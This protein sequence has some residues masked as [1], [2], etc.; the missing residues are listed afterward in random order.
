MKKIYSI[1][2]LTLVVFI[3]NT[4]FGQ[5]MYPGGDTCSTAV[6]I[7]VAD[8]YQTP[9]DGPGG[10]HWYSFVAPCDG[11]LAV[12]D[13]GGLNSDKRIHSGVCGSLTL[14]AAGTWADTDVEVTMSSGDSVYIVVNDNWEGQ[15]YFN[16]EFDGCAEIDSALLDIQGIVYYDMNNNGV[17][18]LDESGTFLTPIISD[19]FGVFTVSGVDGLYYSSVASLDDGNYTI[20]PNL[21]E[22]WAVSSDSVSY[23]FEVND[24]YEQLD[25]L[26]FGLYPDSLFNEVTENLI[27]SFPRCN[28]TINYWLNIQNTGTTV[29]SGLIHL[30][31][32]DSLYYVSADVA[33]DSIVGQ[34]L[35]WNYEDL[36]FFDHQAMVVQV[37]TP[38]GLA[39]TVSSN[40]NV[41][42]DSLGVELFSST[43]TLEQIIVCAYD[44]NDKTPTPLGE[45]E[46]GY[47]PPT[48]ETIEYLVR[49]QN[50]GTDTAFNVVITDQLDANLDWYSMTPLAYSH[51]MH[52]EMNIDGEVSFIFN[53][54]MLPDSNVNQLGSQGFV[55]Y[56]I[57][58]LPGLPLETSI[59]NTA[60]IYF[61]MNPAVVTNTTVNTLHLDVSSVDELTKKDEVLVYPNPFSET[62]T[63][64]F[65]KDLKNYSVQIVDL[66][67]NQVY[68]NNGLSGNQLE[69]EAGHFKSGMYILI[70]VDNE[71]NQIH[72]NTKLI[73]N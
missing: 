31:L 7:P 8:G 62:T 21:P 44:P 55:K 14:E 6:P 67:G 38:D 50:T 36:F 58:L 47:I 65:G 22:H 51:N 52:Y 2:K 53:D 66:L 43:Q 40:L 5:I 48:T 24:A 57:D 1:L 30:A 70:L 23:S 68:L 10:D 46:F 63:V 45:G 17:R 27:G 19:P 42:I 16:V 59:Y 25:S 33:P 26:D 29:T 13:A 72:S 71:S 18:D 39:D 56:R 35:Y 49:F 9:A 4:S 3:A 20:Y 28:D 64:Y 69:I 54:I 60:N 61:D 15:A 12:T 41:T 37:G 11:D 73:V 34:N 32:D